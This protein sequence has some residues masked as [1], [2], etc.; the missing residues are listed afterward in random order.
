[1]KSR[2]LVI[3]LLA[4]FSSRKKEYNCIC[5]TD[6]SGQDRHSKY[7]KFILN[8]ITVES[9]T[10]MHL[11]PIERNMYFTVCFLHRYLFTFI[12]RHEVSANKVRHS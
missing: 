8:K 5:G 9:Q 1:M 4:S 6:G 10:L 11:A 3:A 12:K 7:D 2:L